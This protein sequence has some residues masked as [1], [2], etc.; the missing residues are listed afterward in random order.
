VPIIN[1]ASLP[2][3]NP[4]TTRFHNLKKG[5]YDLDDEIFTPLTNTSDIENPIDASNQNC[6]QGK[7]LHPQA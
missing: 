6:Q 7:M 1:D 3:I 4:T 5:R 2:I